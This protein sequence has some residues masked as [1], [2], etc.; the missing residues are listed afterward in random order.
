MNPLALF[1]ALSLHY[2]AKR[3]CYCCCCCLCC[4]F[5]K[6]CKLKYIFFIYFQLNFLAFWTKFIFIFLRRGKG[7]KK[8]FRIKTPAREIYETGIKSS[9]EQFFFCWNF[10]IKFMLLFL[11]AR[12]IWIIL[13]WKEGSSVELSLE[14]FLGFFA[15]SST[16]IVWICIKLILQSHFVSSVTVAGKAT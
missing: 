9:I 7:K 8:V 12:K 2:V 14:V 3:F 11:I 4:A 1:F 5:N 13:R 15:N 10:R 6:S 16:K